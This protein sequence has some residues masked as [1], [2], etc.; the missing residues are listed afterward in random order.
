M[1]GHTEGIIDHSDDFTIYKK[2][3]DRKWPTSFWT[4]LLVLSRR[5]VLKWNYS[6]LSGNIWLIKRLNQ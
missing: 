6:Q 2:D 3:Y 5:Y 4:Q 1:T